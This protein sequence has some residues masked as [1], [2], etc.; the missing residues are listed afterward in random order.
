MTR[1]ASYLARWRIEWLFLLLRCK[2]Y[3]EG[4]ARKRR[5][6]R[7]EAEK[8]QLQSLLSS[9]QFLEYAA[10]FRT[11]EQLHAEQLDYLERALRSFRTQRQARDLKQTESLLKQLLETG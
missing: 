11:I 3:R 7:F 8:T 5:R 10:T 2:V 6:E 1:V 4:V 9:T